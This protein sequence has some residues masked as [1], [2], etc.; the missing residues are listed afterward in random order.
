MASA[1]RADSARFASPTMAGSESRVLD[2]RQ[3]ETAAE[4]PRRPVYAKKAPRE[5]ALNRGADWR[6]HPGRE[7][8][9]RLALKHGQRGIVPPFKRKRDGV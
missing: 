6:A 3:T 5:W 2:G 4:S 1:V 7:N 9:A 8:Q